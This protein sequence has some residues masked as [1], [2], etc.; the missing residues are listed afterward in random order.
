VIQR[1][2]QIVNKLS[3]WAAMVAASFVVFIAF[4]VTYDVT[5]RKLWNAPTIWV[6]EVSIYLAI[7]S[8]MLG[9]AYV[10]RTNHHIKVDML[11]NKVSPR[12]RKILDRISSIIGAVVSAL[13]TYKGIYMVLETYQLNQTSVTLLETPLFIPQSS[14]PIGA[15]LWFLQFVARFLDPLAFFHEDT[16]YGDPSLKEEESAPTESSKT[17]R[18]EKKYVTT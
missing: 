16:V 4:S 14:I 3:E 5:A 17:H 1:Y 9:S 7:A 18:E 10:L 11:I 2:I 8:V 15:A 13:I 6:Y 12:T